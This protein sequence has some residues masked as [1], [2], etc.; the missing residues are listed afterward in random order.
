MEGIG[1]GIAE[2]VCVW[3]GAVDFCLSRFGSGSAT[4]VDV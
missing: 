4:E 1:G 3:S 2:D